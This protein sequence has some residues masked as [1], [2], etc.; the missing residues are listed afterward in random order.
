M[1]G[2]GNT[3]LPRIRDDERV[4]VIATTDRWYGEHGYVESSYRGMGGGYVYTV[5][6]DH[7]AE[8]PVQYYEDELQPGEEV[9]T[10]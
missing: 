10:K 1:S 6:L 2:G 4:T 3:G 9:F 7:R 8:H 5:R